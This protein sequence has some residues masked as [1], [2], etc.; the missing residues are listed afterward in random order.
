MPF[1]FAR[2]TPDTA[3]NW[4]QRCSSSGVRRRLPSAK[5]PP[6]SEPQV[7]TPLS[8]IVR[9]FFTADSRPSKP[10]S[11]VGSPPQTSRAWPP[12]R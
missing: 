11:V 6:M 4:I 9:P 2:M 1:D 3:P 7:L 10:Q 8:P 12:C 5:K